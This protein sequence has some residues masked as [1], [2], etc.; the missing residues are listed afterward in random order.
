MLKWALFEPPRGP[1]PA[2]Y[3]DARALLCGRAGGEPFMFCG[4]SEVFGPR[5]EGPL[6]AWRA[7]NP[8]ALVASVKLRRDLVDA[9]FARLAGVKAL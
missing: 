8:G 9:D 5:I 3:A 7:A 6:A 4:F 2:G 1:A